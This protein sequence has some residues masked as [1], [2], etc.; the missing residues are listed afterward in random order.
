MLPAELR[1]LGADIRKY[2]L[3]EPVVLQRR[4]RRR[5]DGS[6][7]NEHDYE[8]VL[9]D[10]RNRLDAMER[11]GFALIRDGK[12][13]PAL[14][15]KA[16]GLEPLTGAYAELD[17]D[18]DVYAFVVSRNFHRRHLTAKQK[19][20]LIAKL[21][22]ATPEKS[23]RQIAETVKGDH[24]TVGSVRTEME[25][26][27][28]IPHVVERK[29]SKGR[30]QPA[31]KSPKPP[32]TSLASARE[33]DD[34]GLNGSGEAERLRARNE[35]LERENH[36]LERE[37]LAL[38]SEVEELKAELAKRAPIDDGLPACLRRSAGP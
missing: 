9:V 27:G 25:R 36:R 21:I 38:R 16:L 28:E 17:D 30:S 1:E 31:L 14:G 3:H 34:I 6:I 20:K 7:A 29:D 37:N 15:H 11:A 5:A 18:V 10:G 26:R 12:L 24:K 13:G 19:R 23:D 2:G 33:I 22:K 32:N 35:E 8:L 4:Y